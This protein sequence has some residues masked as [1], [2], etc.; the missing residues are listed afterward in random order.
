[1]TKPRQPSTRRCGRCRQ[2][3]RPTRGPSLTGLG[4]LRTHFQVSARRGLTKFVGR[5]HEMETLKRAL[6][7]TKADHGQI[8]DDGGPGVGSSRLL[9]EFKAVSKK[10]RTLEAIKR[11]LLRESLN[12]PLI[13]NFESRSPVSG[14]HLQA[15]SCWRDRIHLRARAVAEGRLQLAAGRSSH[16]LARTCWRSAGVEVR[17][18]V[19]RPSERTGTSL[20]SHNCIESQSLL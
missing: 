8:V 11:I 9:F 18:P 7:Q 6:E 13:V 2:P 15:T 16:A 14:V 12:Q 20:Q 19:G 10:R 3:S 4:S 17:R 5:Q 1:V